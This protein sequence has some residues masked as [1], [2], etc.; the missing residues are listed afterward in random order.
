[1]VNP[2][3]RS[4]FR[5]I[6]RKIVIGSL[7]YISILKPGKLDVTIEL[8]WTVKKK[9]KDYIALKQHWGSKC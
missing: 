9:F 4:Q 8:Y 3:F 7:K 2:D 1:M 5:E 6:L